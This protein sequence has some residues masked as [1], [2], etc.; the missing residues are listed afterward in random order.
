M[1][2]NTSYF[3]PD[4]LWHLSI[5]GCKIKADTDQA[6]F[7][8]SSSLTASESGCLRQGGKR[9]SEKERRVEQEDLDSLG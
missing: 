7:S 3:F 9:G 2:S 1:L 5:I 6:G 8:N 4:L